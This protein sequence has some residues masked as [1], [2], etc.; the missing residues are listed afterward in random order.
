MVSLSELISKKQTIAKCSCGKGRTLCDIGS[1]TLRRSSA[2][3]RLRGAV[4]VVDTLDV[5]LTHGTLR[6]PFLVKKETCPRA[7]E[8]GKPATAGYLTVLNHLTDH[9]AL[10]S[11][12]ASS[13]S[14]DSLQ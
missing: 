10:S 13:L 3:G 12:L 9:R 4:D 5:T 6:V 2:L 8:Q 7:Y 14:L 11:K 1:Y